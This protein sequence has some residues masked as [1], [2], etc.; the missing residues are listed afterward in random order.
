MKIRPSEDVGIVVLS[1]IF[2]E[3][4]E[5][6]EDQA[7]NKRIFLCTCRRSA[8]T[9]AVP[10][11]FKIEKSRGKRRLESDVSTF[12]QRQVDFHSTF[13]QAGRCKGEKSMVYV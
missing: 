12:Q 3:E 13:L 10:S 9:R 11:S 7:T 4:R 5:K 6:K 1:N 2:E 8:L